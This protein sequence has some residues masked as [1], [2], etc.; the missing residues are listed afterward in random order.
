MAR[1]LFLLLFVLTMVSCGNDRFV[2]Y[3][4]IWQGRFQ[5]EGPDAPKDG[6]PD[7][8]WRGYLQLY[9]TEEKFILHLESRSLAMDVKGKWTLKED[10]R[11][12]LTPEEFTFDDRGG[13]LMRDQRLKP[14]DPKAIQ[15][16]YGRQV[17]LDI[18][19]DRK[20]LT[21][22][23]TRFGPMLGRHVFAKGDTP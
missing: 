20:K 19:P 22:L 11:V 3:I 4:G 14:L 21:G 9:R 10:M 5:A 1:K 13:Q 16:S 8:D 7:R 15:E 18:S 23:L 2:P 12:L 17:I 6:D